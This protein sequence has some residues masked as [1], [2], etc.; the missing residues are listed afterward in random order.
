MGLKKKIYFVSGTGTDVGKSVATGTIAAIWRGRGER[1]VT[2]KLVQTGCDGLSEDIALHR[3]IMGIGLLPEDLD[4]TTCPLRFTYP[5]S[6][7]LAARIDGRDVDLELADRCTQKLLE[8]YDTLLIEGAGG[9]MV[10]LNDTVT[11]L[12]YVR[13]R[14]LPLILVT[15][16]QLGSIN[17]T[18]LTI[19]ACRN[20]GIEIAM[21]VYNLHPES[22][23][24][25]TEDTRRFLSSYAAA[26]LPNC[27]FLEIPFREGL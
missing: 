13:Q 19:E 10:P 2:Q 5:C 14:R 26:K 6:P 8:K 20:N 1:V 21:L 9:L 4:G 24:E 22:S 23:P 3:R 15:T 7:H 11:T 18:L 17:H 27:E 16:P 12:D 25:I